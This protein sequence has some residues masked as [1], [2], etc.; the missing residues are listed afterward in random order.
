MLPI[1][2]FILLVVGSVFFLL[3]YSYSP[4]HIREVLHGDVINL[5]SISGLMMLLCGFFSSLYRIY[6]VIRNVVKLNNQEKLLGFDFNEEMK[7]YNI[8][9]TRYESSD[10]FI[11]VRHNAFHTNAQIVLRRDFIQAATPLVGRSM[12]SAFSK[13][14][15]ITAIDGKKYRIKMGI[16]VKEN[17]DHLLRFENWFYRGRPKNKTKKQITEN[18]KPSRERKIRKNSADTKMMSFSIGKYDGKDALFYKPTK[19]KRNVFEAEGL[20]GYPVDWD[21]LAVSY[22]NIRE[23]TLKDIIE[24][25]FDEKK[26]WMF[27]DDLV[28]LKGFAKRFQAMCDDEKEMRYLLSRSEEFEDD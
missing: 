5:L 12:G 24:I 15:D 19:F 4:F 18:N 27:S 23:A 6:F 28:L 10:W 25:D 22:L 16:R 14:I 7:R 8:T 2:M 1:Q 9:T 13:S 20:D 26:F 3:S 17:K 11:D 21:S